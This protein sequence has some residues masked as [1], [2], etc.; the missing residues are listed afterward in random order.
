MAL[1]FEDWM[2]DSDAVMWQIERDPVLRS[3]IT[4]VWILDQSPDFK[5]FDATFSRALEKIPRLRQRVVAD[6]FG[7]SP[8]RWEDDPL[9]D[10]DFHVRR[11]RAAGNGTI[12]DLLDYARPL[13]G[14]AFDKDRPLWEFHVV[15]G[16]EGGKAGVVMRLHHAISD[17]VGMVRMTTSLIERTREPRPGR[18]RA[19]TLAEEPGPQN[20]T[21]DMEH[22]A[23]AIQH[24]VRTTAE[25]GLRVGD[26][27]RRGLIELAK[28][29]LDG[30]RSLAETAG[31]VGRLV[32]PAS[33]PLSPIWTDRSISVNLDVLLVAFADL[34]AAAKTVDGTLNDAFVAAIAGGL[35]RYHRSFGEATPELRMSMPIDVRTGEKGDQAGNQFVPARI[36]IPVALEDPSERMRAVQR[37]VREQRE[38]PGLP[39]IDEVSGAINRLGALGA[40][41]FV[42]GMMKA[43][44]F[45]T[46]NVPGPPFP[47]YMGGALI[48]Q[49]FPFGP[50]AG[51]AVNVTLFSYDGV[52]QVG[53]NSDRLAVKEPERLHACLQESFDEIIALA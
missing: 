48:E 18:T 21:G 16:L 40:T 3:T 8:P 14:Q 20:R 27:L 33:A 23:S 50:L 51:A 31:S 46:S 37:L 7:V 13:A 29:P 2:S 1:V 5:R 12:R 19:V 49:M 53:I 15:E 9:F 39:F 34:R 10:R 42:G 22:F 35:H 45:V 52:L 26:A 28:H 6:P 47:V 30:A 4:S 17:G 41:A 11:V 32:K 44:D 38:E 24:R 36:I 43:V 25:R